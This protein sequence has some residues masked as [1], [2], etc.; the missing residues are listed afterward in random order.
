M[1]TCRTPAVHLIR[2]PQRVGSRG[3]CVIGSEGLSVTK[4]VDGFDFEALDDT[5]VSVEV[6]GTR[7]DVFVCDCPAYRR[8]W[9]GGDCCHCRAAKEMVA[10]NHGE[11]MV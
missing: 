1:S 7:S 8:L 10:V 5:V 2:V 6:W 9:R 4:T 3:L 11:I